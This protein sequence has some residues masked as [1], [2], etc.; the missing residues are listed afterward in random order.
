LLF[1]PL[2]LTGVSTSRSLKILWKDKKDK[3][4]KKGKKNK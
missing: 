3:K 4:D 1:F 2:V